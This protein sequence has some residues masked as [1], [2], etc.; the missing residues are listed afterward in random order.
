MCLPPAIRKIRPPEEPLR[1]LVFTA[2][3]LHPFVIG[4]VLPETDQQAMLVLYVA[5]VLGVT[6][7]MLPARQYQGGAALAWC[8]A[9]LCVVSLVG[10]FKGFEWFAPAYLLKLVGSHCVSAKAT[11]SSG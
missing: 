1:P 11:R 2:F 8:A 9:A 5:A 6:A 7:L 4:F 10:D 3:H